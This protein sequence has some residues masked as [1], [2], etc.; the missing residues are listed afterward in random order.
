M[1]DLNR[2]ITMQWR[3]SC[4]WG[5]SL[6]SETQNHKQHNGTRQQEGKQRNLHSLGQAH[7]ASPQW[8]VSDSPQSYRLWTCVFFSP[9]DPKTLTCS[10]HGP[11]Y[12]MLRLPEKL[13]THNKNPKQLS[14][15]RIVFC[16]TTQA[17]KQG[18]RNDIIIHKH[19]IYLPFKWFFNQK[20][21][22]MIAN[23]EELGRENMIKLS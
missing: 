11:P 21:K 16:K 18:H 23:I 15:H 4:F 1:A 17:D 2:N 10:H 6:P 9:W 5:H 14:W 12:L 22:Q 3:R 8:P 13:Q 19:L 20:E 7:Q